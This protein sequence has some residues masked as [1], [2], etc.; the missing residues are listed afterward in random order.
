MLSRYNERHRVATDF[1][2]KYHPDFVQRRMEAEW[3]EQYEKEQKN[4]IEAEERWIE[5][6][7]NKQADAEADPAYIEQ[8]IKQYENDNWGT[9]GQAGQADAGGKEKGSASSGRGQADEKA[10]GKEPVQ[11]G[12]GKEGAGKQ[13]GIRQKLQEL[14]D[15]PEEPAN[16]S[17]ELPKDKQKFFDRIIKAIGKTFKGTLKGI[18]VLSGGEFDR[19]VKAAR[20]GRADTRF[21]TTKSGEVFGFVH[22]GRMVLNGDKMNGHTLLH[23]P[24]HI[25]TSWLKDNNPDM[26][27]AGLDLMKGSDYLKQVQ[28]MDFYKEQAAEM[29]RK[30]VSE[31]EIHDFFLDEALA[32]AVGDV[33]KK[34]TGSPRERFMTWLKNFWNG[35]KEGL[36]GKSFEEMTGMEVSR[37]SF[38]DFAKKMS[39]RMLRG[40]ELGDKAEESE[41]GVK[42]HSED[43]NKFG[44]TP[45]NDV[46]LD[47]KKNGLNKENIQKIKDHA[48]AIISGKARYKRFTESQN[49]GFRKGGDSLVEAT[50]LIEGS[51]KAGETYKGRKLEKWEENDQQEADVKKYAQKSGTWINNTNEHF[52]RQYGEPIDTGGKEAVGVWYDEKRGVVIKPFNTFEYPDLQQAL[53]GIT[54]H[55]ARIPETAMKVTGFG[56]DVEGDF[57]IVVEQRYIRPNARGEKPTP[58]ELKQVA[59]EHGFEPYDRGIENSYRSKEE[60]LHD[61][62]DEN[63][64]KA[65]DGKFYVIDTTM[66]L[67]KDRTVENEIEYSSTDARFQTERTRQSVAREIV[68]E[69]IEAGDSTF[70]DVLNRGEQEFGGKLPQAIEK[71]LKRAFD[72]KMEEWPRT[73]KEVSRAQAKH[74]ADVAGSKPADT[75][76]IPVDPIVTG[77]KPK[78]LSD[79]IFDVSRGCN[80]KMFFKTWK[81]G[82]VCVA[83]ETSNSKATFP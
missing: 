59:M 66:A 32:R 24:A 14:A 60:T 25:F 34:L 39:E 69:A 9:Q 13:S 36:G 53:D 56:K 12:A 47:I 18:D 19:A 38:A 42:F 43:K 81:R 7:A 67:P 33:G 79:V 54:L 71:D 63:V 23:E 21:M 50:L 45:L 16:V 22:N 52:T 3:R 37:M 82:G 20:E 8:T 1:L 41:A 30:G 5:E 65:A 61:L 77:R 70:A 10:G 72:D 80:Q 11:Q 75:G 15:M 31:A 28:R 29:R 74:Y 27:R 58:A 73:P 76:R 68:D 46:Y 35:V 57:N 44:N 51:K 48:A 2:E 64:I 26:H 40:K 83:G 55:N 6:Q 4:D 62:H 17:D 78:D 49:I